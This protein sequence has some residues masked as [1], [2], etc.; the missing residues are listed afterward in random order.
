[1]LNDSS[2][3]V[4]ASHFVSHVLSASR[5]GTVRAQIHTTLDPH[6]QLTA[7]Q[8]LDSA[9]AGLAKRHVHDGALLVIDH[10][11][12]EILGWVVGQ[13]TSRRGAE[14]GYDTVLTARQPGSTMKPCYMRSHWTGLDCSDFDRRLGSV[15]SR[16]RRSAY[17][18]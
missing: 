13:T 2:P 1:V 7:Q 9:L 6:I 8:I 5:A 15:R 4:E 12:N 16:R 14:P 10:Q 3:A 18:S 17:F 11:H